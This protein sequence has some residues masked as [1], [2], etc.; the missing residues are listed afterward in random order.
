MDPAAVANRVKRRL[1]RLKSQRLRL[2]ALELRDLSFKFSLLF[3][4]GV[5][6]VRLPLQQVPQLHILIVHKLI[7][8]QQLVHFL[9]HFLQLIVIFGRNLF[10]VLSQLGLF[11]SND[12]LQVLDGGVSRFD[13]F[14]Q[15][16]L[17]LLT[18]FQL[19]LL[20]A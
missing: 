2:L 8:A 1:Q 19:V 6:I 20:L 15:L 10:G 14:P 18:V 11:L 17:H 3:N 4:H 7:Q 12:H 16:S 5:R 13:R 9:P